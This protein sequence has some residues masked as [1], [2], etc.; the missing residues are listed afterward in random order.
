MKRVLIIQTAFIGDVILATA[1]VESIAEKYPDV[2]IDFLLRRGNEGLLQGNPYINRV[3]IWNKQSSKYRNLFS[4][5][6]K[7][8]QQPY[9]LLINLQRFASSGFISLRVKAKT[10]VGFQQNPFSFCY[11]HK[12]PH[13]MDK[14]KHEIER[15]FDL[16][17]HIGDFELH[18]P[19]LYPS[20]E[21]FK[22]AKE[23]SKGKPII[24]LAP[25]SVWFTKQLPTEK[26]TEIMNQYS[27]DYKIALIGGK[28]DQKYLQDLMFSV[29]GKDVVNLAGELSFLESAALISIAYHTHVNDSAPLHMASAMNAKVIAYFCST[30][31]EFGFGPLSE[32][33]Y[34]KET[35][36]AL[37]CRPC[38]LHGKKSCPE[39][40]FKCGKTIDVTIS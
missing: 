33:F 17:K 29:K 9:D 14:G 34:L 28:S 22:R 3:I 38:G 6:R 32:E 11:D 21:D 25:S 26:W 1:L 4:V 8:K 36:I 13:E 24:V 2:K 7:T 30:I 10:K 16:V 39:G 12:I 18:K 27:S 35:K 19:R 37:D 20:E 40:H 23:I 31:P 5:I 15:N